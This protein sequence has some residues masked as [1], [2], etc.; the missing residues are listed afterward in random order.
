MPSEATVP[1]TPVAIPP[2]AA[3]SQLNAPD[4]EANAVWIVGL[5]LA[6]ALGAAGFMMMRRRKTGVASDPVTDRVYE[7]KWV[8][9]F[10]P[11]ATA[12]AVEQPVLVSEEPA[13]T[14]EARIVHE[15]APMAFRKPAA[16]SLAR[17][18]PVESDGFAYQREDMIA[19]RPSAQNPFLTRKNR[20]RRANFLL[21]DQQAPLDE[22]GRLAPEPEAQA[23]PAK[24]PMQVTY[25]VPGGNVGRG[26]LRPRFG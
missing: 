6:F 3:I 17:P 19:Q 1:V 14:D 21:R 11:S 2:Q 18:V 16:S 4:D 24:R 13:T 25:T 15:P 26:V 12:T 8:E 7:D 22:A 23:E 9:P 10:V 20:L 5:G